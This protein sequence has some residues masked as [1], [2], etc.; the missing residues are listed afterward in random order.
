MPRE[1]PSLRESQSPIQKWSLVTA[2]SS[3][4]IPAASVLRA[5]QAALPG[6]GIDVV[7][8]LVFQCGQN[9]IPAVLSIVYVVSQHF[10][11]RPVRSFNLSI[12][13]QVMRRTHR[14]TDLC[15]PEQ[16]L[17]NLANETLVTLRRNLA[18]ETIVP[19]PM[20][21]EKLRRPNSVHIRRRRNKNGQFSTTY[22]Q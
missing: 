8:I 6:G 14:K 19:K 9:L 13:L 10:F 18:R 7:V 3:L 21:E 1:I 11:H 22:P 17:P 12:G 2:T 16:L 5:T 15:Q 4:G 20:I